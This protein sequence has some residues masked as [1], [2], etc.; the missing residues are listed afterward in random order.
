MVKSSLSPLHG[1]F[2]YFEQLMEI[3]LFL[4][5][6]YNQRVSITRRIFLKVHKIKAVPFVL[7]LYGTEYKY[8][9]CWLLKY[10]FF[11]SFYEIPCHSETSPLPRNM[12]FWNKFVL[13]NR[14]FILLENI[15]LV[16][17]HKVLQPICTVL[18]HIASTN[19]MNVQKM[20]GFTFNGCE[21]KNRC[22]RKHI[23]SYFVPE[24][25]CRGFQQ[26]RFG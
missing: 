13:A 14:M 7:N 4:C 1:A 22:K 25:F 9:Y 24:D 16:P 11:V 26:Q 8:T 3:F 5:K 6:S 12:D 19:S 21:K 20:L 18:I 17:S 10:K 15:H 2:H 23:S